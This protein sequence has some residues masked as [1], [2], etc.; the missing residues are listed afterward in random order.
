MPKHPRC[1]YLATK[2]LIRAGSENYGGIEKWPRLTATELS[3]L[4]CRNVPER[5]LQPL[6]QQM[7]ARQVIT[8]RKQ[9]GCG[10]QLTDYNTHKPNYN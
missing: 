2:P 6:L 8:V 5:R 10:G 3:A 9:K 1:T 7:E 4:L